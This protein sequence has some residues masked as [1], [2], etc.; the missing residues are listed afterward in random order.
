[1]IEKCILLVRD[2][3]Q[4][5]NPGKPVRGPCRY[6]HMTLSNTLS[7]SSNKNLLKADR[8][9][10]WTFCF[11]LE[12]RTTMPV[13]LWICSVELLVKIL[14]LWNGLRK[15]AVGY[16]LFSK[17]LEEDLSGAWVASYESFESAD[18]MLPPSA[19]LL[20][21]LRLVEDLTEPLEATDE[22]LSAFLSFCFF[23]IVG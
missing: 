18:L 21:V 1:M 10:P 13:A 12:G 3:L 14:S 16:P 17:S 11:S 23:D 19:G 20:L 15:R 4:I 9:L 7:T 22:A 8:L 5:S 6:E 2:N